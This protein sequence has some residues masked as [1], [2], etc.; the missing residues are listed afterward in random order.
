MRERDDFLHPLN[1]NLVSGYGNISREIHEQLP[2]CDG[3]VIPY[4]LGGLALGVIRSLNAQGS[5]IPVFIC[6]I[7]DHAP[8][9]RALA[10]G[11]SISGPKLHS[12][13]EAMGTPEVIPDVFAEIACHVE[14]VIT[15]TESEVKEGIRLL[16]ARQGIRAEGAAGATMAAA[17][18][19]KR[20]GKQNPVA[21]LTGGNISDDVFR[22]IIHG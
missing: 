4:G 14:D 17:L 3:L 7:T 10:S 15:V 2:N 12:F 1:P 11:K 21:V 19:L 6:E 16:F 20:M 18:K 22:E 5:R 13:I 8:L 9:S